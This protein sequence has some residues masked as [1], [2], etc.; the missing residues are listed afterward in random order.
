MFQKI[1][2]ENRINITFFAILSCFLLISIRLFYWQVIKAQGLQ[3]AMIK[4]TTSHNT[5]KGSRGKIYTADGHLLVGNQTVF[6]LYINKRE[7]K[8]DQLELIN[9]LGNIFENYY[10]EIAQAIKNQDESINEQELLLAKNL[11]KDEEFNTEAF[12]QSLLNSLSK[13]STWLRLEKSL[14]LTLKTKIEQANIQGLHLIEEAIRY[15]PEGS[16]AAHVTGFVGKDD[17]E[18]NLGYFGVE[19]ALDKELSEQSKN[20]QF[21]KDAKG[22]KLA[23][24]KLDFSNLDGRDI[25]LTIQRDIQFIAFSELI[26]GI[27]NSGSKSGQVVIMDPH[28]GAILAL[29]T[30]PNYDPANYQ[31]FSTDIYSNPTLAELFEPGSIFKIFTLA[32]GLDTQAITPQTICTQCAGP[33][34]FGNFSI[35]TWN[36]QYNPNIDMTEALKKSDNT[37]MVFAVEKIGESRFLEYLK[38]FGIGEA[39]KIDLQEDRSSPLRSKFRPVE[40]AN[41]SFGQGLYTNCLQIVRATSAIANQGI[42]MKPYIIQEVKDHQTQETISYEP[43]I[44]RKVIEKES[45]HE[46]VK[47]M[48]NSAPTR[49]NWIT[50]HYLIAGK[51]G[52]AQIASEQG[53]Y[54]E[55]GTI[56][57]F[58]GF[59]PAQDPKFVMLVK[60]NEPQI[61]PWAE[62]SA[63]PTWYDI[64]DKIMLIL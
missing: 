21:Q 7:I 61:S 9:Q 6:D 43:E 18:N 15:Y 14:P 19:G 41:A 28:S 35:K 1:L 10:R 5:I 20:I 63:V 8:I 4:Q 64:A 55:K 26:K 57:S 60:L 31:S 46:L 54:K 23:D 53:G 52:T 34:V 39:I 62:A 2:A 13:T 42:M 38:K 33:R 24:Q 11:L 44:V 29:A 47:M 17:Q 48:I 40:L 32:I 45:A 30:W 22:A 58:V 37:A 56:A 49:N 51:T 25:T 50:Q 27:K 12:Q 16:M 36:E 59:A 3:S